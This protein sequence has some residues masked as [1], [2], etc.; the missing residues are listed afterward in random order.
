MVPLDNERN[1]Y[2]YHHLFAEVMRA[3]LATGAMAE[4]VATLHRRA[5]AWYE[6]EGLIDEA[7]RHALAAPDAE[8]ATTL[9]ERYSE[10]ML[11]RSE[12]LL[13]RTW[14]EQLPELLVQT[15]PRLILARGWTLILTGHYQA[16]AH[17]LATPPA[18]TILQQPDLPA[19]VLG[20][21]LVLRATIARFQRD[22]A[23]VQELAQQALNYLPEDRRGMRA[24]ATFTIGL[25]QLLQGEIGAASQTL[26]EAA[27]LGETAEGPYIAISALEE[28]ASIQLRQGHLSRALQTCHQVVRLVTRW[29]GRPIPAAGMVYIYIGEILYERNDLEGAGQALTYGTE[30]LKGSI[31]Q[32]LLVQGYMALG[33]IQQVQGDLEGALATL[34][35]VEDWFGQMQ[36][37]ISDTGAG[38]LLALGKARL[39]IEREQLAPA[40][41]WAQT[42]RWWDK[43]TKVGYLQQLT[44]VRLRLAQSRLE[45][46]GP[47]LVEASELLDPLL[48]RAEASGWFGHLLEILILQALV[49]QTQGDFTGALA[50]LER[51]LTL[52]E[53][54][55]YVRSFVDEGEPLRLLM[56]EFR[57]QL[58][59][60]ASPLHSY[61]DSL[62][63]AFPDS[64]SPIPDLGLKPI[65]IQ[66]P[67][68]YNPAKSDKIRNLIDPLS[69]REQELLRLV[70]AGHTNQEIAQQLFL[71][72]GTVK[73]HLNNIFGKLGVSNRT[74]AIARAR[75]FGIVD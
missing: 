6:A 52:A 43:G 35:R 24:G 34:Q 62:L 37:Q 51:A 71:A 65:T 26:A 7:I 19:A 5:S 3:R 15:R 28:L 70:A 18:S 55:G 2:R 45:P 61:L 48:A 20:E 11:L 68:T 58:E 8:L 50:S 73:K 44:L 33:R 38:A 75:E 36:I 17:W 41:H 16:A 42:C 27:S 64:E 53:P 69:L 49:Y 47:F 22:P 39:W 54:G 63:A 74:Q 12:V 21:L 25:A 66:N 32:A 59:K 56:L 9:V 57:V 60:Q 14:L 30:L 1:W 46:K 31:E 10:A 23:L 4:T 13:I 40:N 72:V 29:G 67:K